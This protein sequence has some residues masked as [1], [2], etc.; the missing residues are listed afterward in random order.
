MR[1]QIQEMLYIEKDGDAQLEDELSAYNPLIPQGSELI[2]T[3]MFEIDEPA[4]RAAVLSHLGGIEIH[5]F[6][7]VAGERI[8]GQPHPTR[9]NIG[10]EGKASAVQFLKF[11]FTRDQITLSRHRACRSSS[12]SITLITRTWRCCRSGCALHCRTISTRKPQAMAD[13]ARQREKHERLLAERLH[14]FGAEHPETLSAMLDLAD[15][16]WAQGRL[17]SARKLEEQV[18]A[19][20]RHRL[21]EKHF[22]T[23]KAIGKLAVTMAAQGDL[24]E[25][26]R[27][28]E[29]VL[30]GMRELH[31]DTGLE[32][33]RAINNLAGTVSAQGDFEAARELLET[34]V[35]TG[36]HEFGEQHADSLTAMGNLAAI[37]WQQG[38]RGAAYALQ[39][40]VV[41]TLRR[42]HG[43]GD[44]ATGAAAQVLEMMERDAG[45]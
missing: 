34:A 40:H 37:L 43:D 13:I 10:A 12:V 39:Q 23:L 44:Q 27:L 32:T 1:Q 26:R 21:G 35:A 9:E 4:R 19:G 29:C 2:A 7:D 28:Q 24:A 30:S 20:R 36:C 45:L 31:G 42:V 17:I 8:R 18:V 38:D 22:D 25:A 16:L 15:C 11:P 41:E 6:L 5:A 14:A 3:I 33:L